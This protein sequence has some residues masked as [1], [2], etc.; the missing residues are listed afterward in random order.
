MAK[1]EEILQYVVFGLWRIWKC[2]NDVVF[3]GKTWNPMKAIEVW[4]RH[5]GEHRVFEKAVKDSL[6][7]SK[8][9]GAT[10]D[11]GATEGSQL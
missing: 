2:I 7:N 1:Q 3:Q 8:E 6:V 10:D 9:I 11:G 5:V 4:R